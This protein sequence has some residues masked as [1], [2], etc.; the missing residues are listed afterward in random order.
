MAVALEREACEPAIGRSTR[1]R[2][3]SID[4]VFVCTDGV[5][6]AD[7]R[8]EALPAHLRYIEAVI[9]RVRLAGPLLGENGANIGSLYIIEADSPEAAWQV[10]RGDPFH[11]AGIWQTI[12]MLRMTGAAG[13]L[14]GGVTWSGQ[15]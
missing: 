6:S 4:F 15:Q 2:V 14:L 13:T 5:D 9:A 7:R 12:T 10:L 11:A 1:S 8:R 3:R